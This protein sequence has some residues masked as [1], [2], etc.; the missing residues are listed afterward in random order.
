MDLFL[1]ISAGIGV[2]LATG[3]RP[4][5]A[6]LAVGALANLGIGLDFD[7]T[8]YEFLQAVPFLAAMLA[9]TVAV[10]LY[11]RQGKQIPLAAAALAGVVL[12]ALEFAGA[13]ADRGESAAPG[14]A[15]GA[16][17]ALIGLFAVRAFFGGAE[18]RLVAQGQQGGARLLRVYADTAAWVTAIVAVLLPPL[19]YVALAFCVWVLVSS[20][21]RSGKK[22]EGLRVLR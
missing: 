13:L 12:G 1:A 18:E 5:M 17:F 9:L 11:E 22:Y 20:R 10:T 3:A 15:A 19:S 2:S 16:I 6:A 14:L 8:D 21:R 4:F 7:G